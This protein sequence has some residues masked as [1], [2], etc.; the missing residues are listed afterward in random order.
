MAHPLE[1]VTRIRDELREVC[2]IEKGMHLGPVDEKIVGDWVEMK[3]VHETSSEN[4]GQPIAGKRG[5]KWAPWKSDAESVQQRDHDEKVYHLAMQVYC[6]MES[7]AAYDVKKY[8]W[9]KPSDM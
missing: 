4:P 8:V 2:G 6:D 5:C 9:P 1:E 7:G 3:L